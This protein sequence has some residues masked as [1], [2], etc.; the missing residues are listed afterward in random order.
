MEYHQ[1][2]SLMATLTEQLLLESVYR[3][4]HYAWEDYEDEAVGIDLTISGPCA[5]GLA[6]GPVFKSAIAKRLFAAASAEL[7]SLDL[8]PHRN[9][10]IMRFRPTSELLNAGEMLEEYRTWASAERKRRR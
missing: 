3:C 2:P 5:S 9:G 7:L 6:Y 4:I 10:I 1:S 8:M